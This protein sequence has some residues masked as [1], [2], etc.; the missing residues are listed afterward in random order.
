MKILLAG[1]LTVFVCTFCA[2]IMLVLWAWMMKRDLATPRPE[3]EHNHR[4]WRDYAGKA[5]NRGRRH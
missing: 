3:T 2:G 4:F 1:A 5:E